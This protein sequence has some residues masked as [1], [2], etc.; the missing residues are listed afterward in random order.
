MDE[1]HDVFCGHRIQV[2][3]IRGDLRLGLFSEVVIVL[4]IFFQALLLNFTG[5]PAMDA[6][7]YSDIS[8]RRKVTRAK[9]SPA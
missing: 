3:F 1:L 2:F 6:V 5:R 8:V 9:K 4:F 7:S